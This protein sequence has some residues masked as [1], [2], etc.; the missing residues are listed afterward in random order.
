GYGATYAVIRDLEPTLLTMAHE[1]TKAYS[2]SFDL[3][4]R[5]EADAPNAIWQAD[6]TE[7]DILVKDGNGKPRRPWLTIILDDYSRAIA[8]YM[9]FFG[10]GG[11]A[12][13]PR[14]PSPV[15]RPWS[16]LPVPRELPPAWAPRRGGMGMDTTFRL[17]NLGRHGY[18]FGLL[19]SRHQV[20]FW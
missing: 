16:R 8:G 11:V 13:R 4:H 18:H 9:L 7:L 5:T 15:G 14:G 1:G 10:V 6:H 17:G 19:D 3:I 12:R 20:R 2:E